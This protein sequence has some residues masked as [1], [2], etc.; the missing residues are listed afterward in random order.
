MCMEAEEEVN[1]SSG[2]ESE[3]G[4]DI[5]D[6]VAKALVGEKVMELLL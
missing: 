3:W 1:P 5:F 6:L 2:R 4:K